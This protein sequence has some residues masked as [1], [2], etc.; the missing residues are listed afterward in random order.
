MRCT[1]L[2]RTESK[3]AGHGIS[4]HREHTTL[5]R[6]SRQ[7]GVEKQHAALVLPARRTRATSSQSHSASWIATVMTRE[8]LRMFGHVARFLQ[9]RAF[10]PRFLIEIGRASC[11]E[12]V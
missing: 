12:R 3:K 7:C 4:K 9:S 10:D 2:C 1:R 6:T 8:R 5:A 11:R